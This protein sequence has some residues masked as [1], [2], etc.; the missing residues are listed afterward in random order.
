MYI[1]C[2]EWHVLLDV[3]GKRQYVGDFAVPV[4]AQV[5]GGNMTN[6][7]LEVSHQAWSLNSLP[8]RPLRLSMR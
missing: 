6:F 8:L 5:G 2:H 7:V 3:A 4:M 1:V